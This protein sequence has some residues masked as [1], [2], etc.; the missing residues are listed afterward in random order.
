MRHINQFE[1][2]NQLTRDLA[3]F[4]D[5]LTEPWI[6]QGLWLKLLIWPAVWCIV[7]AILGLITLRSMATRRQDGALH[8]E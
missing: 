1:S 4:W 8:E 6:N 3:P 5:S 7:I 2:A